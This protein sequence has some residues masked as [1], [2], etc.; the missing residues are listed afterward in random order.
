MNRLART[1]LSSVIAASVVLAPSAAGASDDNLVVAVNRDDNRAM[2][3]ASVD[4]RKS[5][6]GVVDEENR[7][8]AV[9]KC[10]D[11]QTLA[12]AF[13]LVLVTKP[14]STFAPHNEGLATNLE[15]D[16]CVTWA[17]AKQIVVETGGP[18]AL[19]EAGHARLKAVEDSLEAL[20]YE[21]PT[22]TLADLQAAVDAAFAEFLDVALTEIVR[23]DDGPD[24]D[25]VIATQ[26]S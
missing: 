12:A 8:Y 23:T 20:R 6:N 26:S 5:A 7:A 22:M 10:T 4:Y 1:L 25:R 24:D 13:Q 2:V 3:R 21:M 15:C 11:C 9:A 16:G 17:S 18:A 19:S 14:P